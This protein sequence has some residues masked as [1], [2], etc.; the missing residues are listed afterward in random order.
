MFFKEVIIFSHGDHMTV[1]EQLKELI[2]RYLLANPNTSINSLSNKSKVGA[3]TLR[4]IINKTLKGDPSPH[5]SLNIVSALTNEK[6]LGH[7][8]K[9][10]N[11]PLGDSLNDAFSPYAEVESRHI[12]DVDINEALN[13]GMTYLIYKLAANRTGVTKIAIAESFGAIGI[14]K[15][16]SLMDKKMVVEEGDYIHA[17]EKDFSLDIEIVKKHL[18][19]LMKFYKVENIERGSNVLYSLSET[20]NKDGVNKIREIS[21]NAAKEV[22]RV[23]NSPYY[24]G[25]IPFFSIILG[26]T[27]A[28]ESEYTRSLQ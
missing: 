27:L 21:R 24:E 26:D 6:K 28:V 14:V 17:K 3:T 11:G 10:F 4:R 16:K 1:S 19:E 2:D 25:E 7:L 15:L 22:Y 13:D 8:I 23:L 12:N 5:T 20:I 18:P 9:M